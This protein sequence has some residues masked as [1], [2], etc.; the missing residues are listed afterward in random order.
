MIKYS[1]LIK[2]KHFTKAVLNEKQ[3]K[4]HQQLSILNSLVS[5]SSL[6][7]KSDK[8]SKENQESTRDHCYHYYLEFHNNRKPIRFLAYRF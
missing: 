7:N 6:N 5:A 1:T 2:S 3:K 8:E 4:V